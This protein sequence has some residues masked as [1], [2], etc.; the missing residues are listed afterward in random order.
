MAAE[1]LE[2]GGPEEVLAALALARESA[3]VGA[4]SVST[5]HYEGV[6]AQITRCAGLPA[7]RPASSLTP[8]R[9]LV[10][11]LGEQQLKTQWLRLRAVASEEM[12]AVAAL[13][14]ACSAGQEAGGGAQPASQRV[15]TV[16][17]PAASAPPGV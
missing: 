1:W 13:D 11:G 4:Y 15:H 10:R 3:T 5:V 16:R 2:D 6:V 7:L 17:S 14:V 12:E 8:V 9:S